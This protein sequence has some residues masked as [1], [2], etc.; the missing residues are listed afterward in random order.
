MALILL[1]GLPAAC[2]PK[3][4]FER[5]EP[6]M[7]QYSLDVPKGWSRQYS[8]HIDRRPESHVFFVG[9]IAVKSDLPPIGALVKIHKVYRLRRDHPGSDADFKEHQENM[10]RLDERFTAPLSGDLREGMLAG[11]PARIYSDARGRDVGVHVRDIIETPAE[12]IM[13]RTD[14]AYYALTYEATKELFPVHRAAFERM[15]SSFKIVPDRVIPS[16]KIAPKRGPLELTLSLGRRSWTS[17]EMIWYRLEA[18]NHSLRPIYVTDSF[19]WDQ[20]HLAENQRAKR[21]TYFEVEGPDGKPVDGSFIFAWGAHGEF[22]FWANDCGEGRSCRSSPQIPLELLPGQRAA[23]SPSVVAPIRE[24]EPSSFVLTDARG[25]CRGSEKERKVSRA[26]FGAFSGLQKEVGQPQELDDICG[27][28]APRYPGM[29]ILEGFHFT[30]PGYYRIR[31]VFAAGRAVRVKSNWA[32]FEVF[33]AG[34]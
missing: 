9:A 4:E 11:L 1:C 5:Y 25:D 18:K 13:T 14:D 31:A 19:W 8:D 15:R 34:L 6:Y 26:L 20:Y 23:A 29:R 28:S 22:A 30:T 10:K 12:I 33:P 32:E 16:A 21:G 2:S 17:P 24:Q 27:P 3:T 7:G